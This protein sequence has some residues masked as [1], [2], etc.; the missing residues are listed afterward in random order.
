[1]NPYGNR[2][3][4]HTGNARDSKTTRIVDEVEALNLF[5]QLKESDTYASVFIY[6][7]KKPI[8]LSSIAWTNPNFKY[9]WESDEFVRIQPRVDEV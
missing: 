5:H 1:M 2:I 4:Y 6:F 3:T 8:H 9:D 7:D